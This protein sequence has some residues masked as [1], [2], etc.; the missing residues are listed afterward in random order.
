M[1]H[2]EIGFWRQRTRLVNVV[3]ELVERRSE[4]SAAEAR[5]NLERELLAAVRAVRDYDEKEWP[6]RTYRQSRH[7]AAVR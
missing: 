3:L 4:T 5:D 6:H 7:V 1:N 2:E